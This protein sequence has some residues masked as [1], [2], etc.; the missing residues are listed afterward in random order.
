MNLTLLAVAS[1]FLKI[2][3]TSSHLACHTDLVRRVSGNSVNAAKS[4][5]GPTP[6]TATVTRFL[7]GLSQAETPLKGR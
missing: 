6:Q 1:N 2:R 7:A 4:P 5:R 3:L